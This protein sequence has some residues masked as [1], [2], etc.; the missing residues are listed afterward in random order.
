VVD[1][2]LDEAFIAHVGVTSAGAPVVPPMAYGRVDDVLYLHGATAN[3][4]LGEMKGHDACV[5]VT[6]V[7]GVVL[8]RSAFH[9]S[10]NYRSVVLFGVAELVHDDVGKRRAL[11]AIVEQVTPGRSAD[12]RP[13][14]AA[15]LRATAV[16]RF[17]IREGSAKTRSG[18]P[19]DDPEDVGLDIWAGHVPLRSMAGPA[20]PADDLPAGLGTP[21]YAS[22]YRRP[23]T[24]G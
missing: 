3:H 16:L 6:L 14:N 15:E 9:H 24:E 20:V 21:T 11:D 5:T 13:A 2:I 19:I 12:A 1:A 23:G 17:P 7:D 8:A 10:A 22:D 4:L 18:G